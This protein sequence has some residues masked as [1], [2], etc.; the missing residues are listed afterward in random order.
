MERDLA[1]ELAE[2]VVAGDE[3]GFTVDLDDH[4]DLAVGMD[5]ALDDAFGG[6]ALAALGGGSLALDAQDLNCLVD[7]ALGLGERLLARHH[8]GAGLVA[9]RLDGAC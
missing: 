1:S 7:R 9:E 4:T 2:L 8:P 5:V 6:G 3:V